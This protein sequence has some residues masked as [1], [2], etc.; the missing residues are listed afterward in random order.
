MDI[1]IQENLYGHLNRLYWIISH[2]KK[3]DR[4][5]DFGCGTGFMITLPLAKAGY[6]VSG[7]DMDRESIAIGR[8]LFQQ[9]DLDPE[10]LTAS[11]LSRSNISPD[12]LIA[13][14]VLEHIPDNELG[15]I[16]DLLHAKLKPNGLLLVTVPNGYG[17]FEFEKL[18]WERFKIREVV[19]FLNLRFI[20][21]MKTRIVGDYVAAQYPPTLS[22]SPHVQRFTFKGIQKKLIRRGFK[23]IDARGSVI[24]CGPMSSS[25]LTGVKPI[26][27]MNI[28]LGKLFPRFSSGFYI[29]AQ[30]DV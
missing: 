29:A 19:G 27:R 16:L 1:Q 18:L 2:I 5:I 11:D 4:I 17:W 24:F 21:R 25:L 3:E 23:I 28:A 22:E 8:V 30:K 15:G 20:K 12:V 14:E 26:M 6:A 10:I 7:I 9:E 13:S